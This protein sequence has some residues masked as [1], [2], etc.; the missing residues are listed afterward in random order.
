MDYLT[1]ES[2]IHP[3]VLSAFLV[4]K[5]DVAFTVTELAITGSE[6]LTINDVSQIFSGDAFLHNNAQYTVR[7]VDIIRKQ[8]IINALQSDIQAD[9]ALT[10]IGRDYRSSLQSFFDIGSKDYATFANS[11]SASGITIRFDSDVYVLKRSFMAMYSWMLQNKAFLKD[12]NL[13]GVGIEKSQIY[14]H[15]SKLL[16]AEREELESIRKEAMDE[17]AR[18]Q[19][20]DYNGKSGSGFVRY[21]IPNR[22]YFGGYRR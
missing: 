20:A 4:K 22:T 16:E 15:F 17:L 14:E 3:D 12:L 11:L 8:I 18:K 9:T 7:A 2:F 6:Y 21:T 19:E 1:F 10:V 5:A 13:T